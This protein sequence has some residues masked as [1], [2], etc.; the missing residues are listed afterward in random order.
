MAC[1]NDINLFQFHDCFSSR[2]DIIRLTKFNAI[3]KPNNGIFLT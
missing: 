1:V 2:K 3:K